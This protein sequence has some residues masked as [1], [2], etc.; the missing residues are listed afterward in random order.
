MEQSPPGKANRSSVGQNIP[1]IL[2][3]PKIHCRIH[4][5]QPPG[6]G[7]C[8]HATGRPQAADGGTASRYGG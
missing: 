6:G 2:W 7:P 3:N 1:R 8:L 5:Q 4:K